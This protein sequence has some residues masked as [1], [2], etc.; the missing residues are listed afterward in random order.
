M[1]KKK[2]KTIPFKTA[3]AKSLKVKT[4]A[5]VITTQLKKVAVMYNVTYRLRQVFL[6]LDKLPDK[7]EDYR[8]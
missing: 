8:D 3:G 7:V 6:F 2:N 5:K 1:G 4:K